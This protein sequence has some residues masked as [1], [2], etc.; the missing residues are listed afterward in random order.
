MKERL[1]IYGSGT[2]GACL[3]TLAIG[4]GFQTVVLGHSGKGVERCRKVVEQNWDNLIQE[5]LVSN[6]NKTAAME[7]LHVTNDPSALNSC[8]FVYEAVSEALE[9]KYAVYRQIEQQCGPDTVI[10]STTSSIDAEELGSCWS[11]QSGS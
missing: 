6:D 3:A 8:A 2:I 9:T 1:A 7:L 4:N 10:A 11:V 5:G